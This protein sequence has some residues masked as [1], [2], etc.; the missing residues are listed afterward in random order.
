[1][2]LREMQERVELVGGHLTIASQPEVGT[3]VVAEVPL[4]SSKEGE[5]LP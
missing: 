2:G 1:V 5:Q 3:L 4:P